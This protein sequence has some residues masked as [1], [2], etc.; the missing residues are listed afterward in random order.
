MR[1]SSKGLTFLWWQ[2]SNYEKTLQNYQ[3]PFLRSRRVR[4]DKKFLS[5]DQDDIMPES[6]VDLTAVLLLSDTGHGLEISLA[7]YYQRRGVDSVTLLGA[8]DSEVKLLI[9]Q[10][11]EKQVKRRKIYTHPIRHRSS[12]NR[13]SVALGFLLFFS[14]IIC[15]LASSIFLYPVQLYWWETLVAKG[16]HWDITRTLT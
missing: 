4:F 13:T 1:L 8:I 15:I 12:P 11:E 10:H 14:F 3:W 6:L 5:P 9:A 2:N 16:S 7:H